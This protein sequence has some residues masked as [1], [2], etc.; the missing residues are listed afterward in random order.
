[1]CKL[2]DANRKTYNTMAKKRTKRQTMIYK[3]QH[4][5]HKIVQNQ[6]SKD[7][8]GVNPGVPEGQTV[9]APQVAPVVL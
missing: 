7:R 2:E 3:T 4:R 5:K 6:H 8:K 9:P 1:M